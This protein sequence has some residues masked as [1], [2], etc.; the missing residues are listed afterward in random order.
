MLALTGNI[1]EFRPTTLDVCLEKF[2]KLVFRFLRYKLR[3]KL[4]MKP[5]VSKM[6]EDG[7]I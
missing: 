5:G 1:K 2:P 3:R 6:G 4:N 7:I